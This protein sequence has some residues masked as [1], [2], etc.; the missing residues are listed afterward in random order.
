MKKRAMTSEHAR[1]VRQRGHNN[2]GEFALLIGMKEA[3]KNDLAA[4]KD[5][6]DPSGDSHSVKGGDKKWQIFLYGRARF[7][8]DRNFQIG[9]I[10]KIIVDALDCFPET[11]EEYQ[12]DKVSIKNEFSANIVKL[13]EEL[14]DSIKLG[15]FIS[16]AFF[17]L[18]EVTY[19]TVKN[20]EVY[21]VFLAEDVVKVLVKC[22]EIKTSKARR[23]GELSDQK[24]LLCWA[25]TTLG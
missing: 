16:K 5:V 18:G 25:G 22:L 4:K 24:V 6:I 17:N 1:F 7:A 19:L 11:F 15:N 23:D 20:D 14:K 13:A 8:T 21:H 10:G 12:R 9:N 3:Y 2:A